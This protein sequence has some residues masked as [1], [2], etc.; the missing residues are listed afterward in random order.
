MLATNVA[1]LLAEAKQRVLLVDFDLEAPGISN[2]PELRPEAPESLPRGV[3]GHLIDSW[4]ASQPQD[5][6]RYCHTV[7]GFDGRLKVMPAGAVGTPAFAD[8]WQA[9]R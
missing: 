8:D 4:R 5:I 2:L 7:P 6:A 3:A 9:L 1:G